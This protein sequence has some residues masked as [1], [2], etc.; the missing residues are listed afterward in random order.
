MQAADDLVPVQAQEQQRVRVV[1]HI[2]QGCG[3]ACSV[4]GH[5][6]RGIQ[7]E[8]RFPG[9]LPHAGQIS[10]SILRLRAAQDDPPAIPQPHF[11]W[12]DIHLAP[13]TGCCIR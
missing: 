4:G 7:Q 13:H 1:P 12:L 11:H 2:L 10:G 3:V 9:D 5:V 8:L 6:L